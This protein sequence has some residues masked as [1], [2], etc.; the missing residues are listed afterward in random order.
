MKK[1]FSAAA[2]VLAL[3][4]GAYAFS[5]VLPAGASSTSSS[6]A[7]AL[8]G[9]HSGARVQAVLDKLV[10]DGTITKDQEDKILAA[11]KDAAPAK[12]EFGR[13]GPA[14]LHKAVDT[15]AQ[16]L[17]LST[18][19]LKAELKAGKSVADVAN[20]KG[21]S[22]DTVTKALTDAA[23]SALDKAVADGKITQPR[24]DEL[25][26]KLPDV[27]SKFENAKF[28]MGLRGNKHGLPES[29]DSSSSSSS[30]GS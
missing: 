19:D 4:I 9:G 15:A 1:L 8:A 30:S 16:A 14:I 18:S 2:V 17:G 23:N 28:P 22:L 10:A 21:V 7:D 3:G 24:A 13:G 12:G 20:E 11:L 5:T 27:I 26:A 29:P 6:I 25:K